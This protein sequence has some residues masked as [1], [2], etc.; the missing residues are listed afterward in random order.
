[1]DTAEYRLYLRTEGREGRDV[2]N[3]NCGGVRSEPDGHARAA[4][5]V[6]VVDGVGEVQTQSDALC[7]QRSEDVLSNVTGQNRQCL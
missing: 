1:M 4:P 7:S 6:R 2:T 5:Q 3:R